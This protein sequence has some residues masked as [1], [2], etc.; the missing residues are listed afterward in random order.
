[1]SPAFQLL[2]DPVTDAVRDEALRGHA[3]A[4]A[5]APV[6]EDAEV[7]ERLMHAVREQGLEAMVREEHC[8]I[9]T[10]PQWR[11]IQCEYEHPVE[12]IPGYQRR[13]RFQLSVERPY[14]APE[15]TLYF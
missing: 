1:M 14:L 3:D 6:A 8:R 12:L 13:L 2:L 15:K 4:L 10:R 7:H 5:G 11:A 9:E